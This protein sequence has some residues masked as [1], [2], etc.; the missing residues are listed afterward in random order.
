M[1]PHIADHQKHLYCRW[2]YIYPRKYHFLKPTKE[3]VLECIKST[4]LLLNNL[5]AVYQIDKF[6]NQHL[7]GLH[8]GKLSCDN[9]T[10]KLKDKAYE[11]VTRKN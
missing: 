9:H 11:L 3:N 10:L 7:F 1:E 6:A 2:A 4:N 5:C 8:Q